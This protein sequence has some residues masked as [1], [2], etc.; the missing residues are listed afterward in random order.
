M[1]TLKGGVKSP[2][3]DTS[4]CLCCLDAMDHT[5]GDDGIHLQSLLREIY[6]ACLARAEVAVKRIKPWERSS[7]LASKKWPW[8]PFLKVTKNVFVFTLGSFRCCYIIYQICQP[9]E[10]KIC[11]CV[12]GRLYH[13]LFHDLLCSFISKWTGI[14][15]KDQ[16]TDSL[17][18]TF[19]VVLF[20]LQQCPLFFADFTLQ[21]HYKGWGYT[22]L[23]RLS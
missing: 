16:E 5:N 18:T 22:S 15:D 4:H 7:N 2:H 6:N 13:L 14:K 9:H 10:T 1:A 8:C 23:L 17:Q 19:I 21:T 3:L 20:V 11:S 12:G